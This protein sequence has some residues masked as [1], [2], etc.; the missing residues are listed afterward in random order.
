MSKIG[1]NDF[2]ERTYMRIRIFFLLITTLLSISF[3]DS[4][5]VNKEQYFDIELKRQINNALL[6][7][8]D[9]IQPQS[10]VSCETFAEAYSQT[11]IVLKEN[12]SS[13][14]TLFKLVPKT[15]STPNVEL[16]LEPSIEKSETSTSLLNESKLLW[17]S[18]KSTETR[19]FGSEIKPNQVARARKNFGSARE[20]LEILEHTLSYVSSS[21]KNKFPNYSQEIYINAAQIYIAL[22]Q[23]RE[24][25]C[26]TLEHAQLNLFNTPE[27]IKGLLESISK[28]GKINL[29]Q[30]VCPPVDF[31]LL[32]SPNPEDYFLVSAERSLL[33]R[34]ISQLSNFITYLNPTGIPI[35]VS[36]I[37]GD[38]DE[39][40]YI[41]PY[42]EK[43]AKLN[44]ERL[45]ERRRKLVSNIQQYVSKKLHLSEIAVYSLSDLQNVP[46]KGLDE[47]D[48][49]KKVYQEIFNHYANYFTP[50]EVDTEMNRMAQLW[51]PEGYYS[52]LPHPNNNETLKKI[53]IA[54]FAAYAVDGVVARDCAPFSLL[55]QTEFPRELRSKM[56]NAGRVLLKDGGFPVIYLLGDK[57]QHKLTLLPSQIKGLTS[58]STFLRLP[59]S[60]SS[61]KQEAHF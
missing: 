54:K 39:E 10:K 44:K 35:K 1:V 9:T 6:C 27:F 56:M 46:K 11:Q 17:D 55:V 13:T 5:D 24:N 48:Y 51:M 37:V 28:T 2:L 31:S 36:F 45:D 53:V 12:I 29:L 52:G 38:N 49:A 26:K 22:F 58:S 30:F 43:Q 61:L 20:A 8:K 47:E 18:L 34:H 15:I 32:S 40:G 19:A 16:L 14:H 57:E 59:S 33:S 25:S 60:L 21:F 4:C 42:L 3:A 41:W 23:W 50:I 7:Y